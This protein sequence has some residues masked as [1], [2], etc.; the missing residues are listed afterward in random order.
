MPLEL[1]DV[2]AVVEPIA[3]QPPPPSGAHPDVRPPANEPEAEKIEEPA[4]EQ[5]RDQRAAAEGQKMQVHP[6]V[7]VV[8]STTV[9]KPVQ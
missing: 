1:S 6:F 8:L 3:R 5:Q 7:G 2:Q 9:G 4:D